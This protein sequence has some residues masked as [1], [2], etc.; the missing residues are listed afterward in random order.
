[1]RGLYDP[2]LDNK[3]NITIII[4]YKFTEFKIHKN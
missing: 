4:V 1:M 3:N 2:I